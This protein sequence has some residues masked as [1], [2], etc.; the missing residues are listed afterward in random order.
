[1]A[2]RSVASAD[3]RGKRVVVRV[4]FNVPLRDGDVVDDTRIR[5]ALPTLRLLLD[6][7]AALVLM[8]HLGRPKGTPNPAY[9]VA[10][11]ARRLSELLGR[12][13]KTVPAVTGPEAERAAAELQ[14]GDVLLLENTRF[15]PGEEKNDAALAAG[16]ARLGDLYVNDA[17]GSAH[18]AHAST[19]GIAERLPTYA[20]LLLQREEEILS[21][22]LQDPERPFVAI[23]GGAKVS[24]KLAVI[25]QLLER[26]DALLLGGGMANTILLA[27]GREIGR[28]LAEPELVDDARRLIATARGRGVALL[29]PTDVVVAPSIDSDDAT[30]VSVDHV[31]AEAAIFDIGPETV[32]RYCEQVGGARTIFWNGPMGVFE[33]PRFATGTIEVARCVADADAFSV[34]GGGD[35]VAAVKAAGVADRIDHISTGGGASLEFLEGRTLPGIAAIP[36]A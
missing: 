13:V 24:D 25:G 9:S 7:G 17:F 21:R 36:N 31:P 18:R 5:A 19:V 8:T 1:M 3:V 23:L 27:Q 26:V 15:E 35:S 14:P 29:L 2:K 28:S 20:G 10:P 6:K 16:L 12:P 30:V 34:V 32:R 22:L 33:R 11:V 4:D